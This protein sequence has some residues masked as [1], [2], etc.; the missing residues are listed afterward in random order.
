MLRQVLIPVQRKLPTR[1]TLNFSNHPLHEASMI[2]VLQMCA[3]R[4]AVLKTKCKL[5]ILKCKYNARENKNHDLCHNSYSNFPL[6]YRF[7]LRAYSYELSVGHVLRSDNIH[8]GLD[9]NKTPINNRKLWIHNMQNKN[10]RNI[11]EHT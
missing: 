6:Q 10:N 8:R 3:T 5:D 2:A 7:I 9:I 1:R 4:P 11:I